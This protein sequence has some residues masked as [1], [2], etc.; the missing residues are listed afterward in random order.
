MLTHAAGCRGGSGECESGD[1][2]S[3][4][5]EEGVSRAGGGGGG[6]KEEGAH[7]AAGSAATDGGGKGKSVGGGDKEAEASVMT[8]ADVC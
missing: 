8:Y 6:G 4:W 5:L 3:E 7:Q 1:A 2:Q